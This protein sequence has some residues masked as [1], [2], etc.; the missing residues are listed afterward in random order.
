MA[1]NIFSEIEDYHNIA[2]IR[3]TKNEIIDDQTVFVTVELD[4]FT[5]Q[6]EDIQTDL[7]K[8]IYTMKTLHTVTELSQFPT[9]WDEKWLKKAISEVDLRA[10]TPDQKLV[11][12][13]AISANALVVKNE[14]R[15][16]TE[17]EQRVK[18]VTVK[19]ALQKGLSVELAA[20]IAEVS[21]DFV[22]NIQQNLLNQN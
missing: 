17:A 19:N 21:V 7:D 3:N 12:E 2:T 4:K 8:L 16:I 14:N 1:E 20:E 13:M 18:T 10:M 15:K 9:F 5:K 11:Y 22:K 6:L